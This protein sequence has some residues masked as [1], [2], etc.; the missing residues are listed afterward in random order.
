MTAANQ[1]NQTAILKRLH[2]TKIEGSLF[3]RSKL[4]MQCGKDTEFRGEGRYVTIQTNTITGVSSDFATAVANEGPQE[5]I[6]FFVTHR[7]EY[8]TFSIDNMLLQ[9]AKEPGPAAMISALKQATD[10]DKGAIYAFNRRVAAGLWGNGGGAIGRLATGTTLSGTTFTFRDPTNHRRVEVG[11][12]LQFSL[13]DGTG[14]SASSA[15]LL[16]S[17]E[18]LTVTGVNRGTGEIT[19][20]QALNNI[21]SITDAAYVFLQGDYANKITGLPGWNPIAAPSASES[22]F[23]IDRSVGD[24]QR[25]AG[26]QRLSLGSDTTYT[27]VLTN[28]MGLADEVAVSFDSLF[29]NPRNWA[30]ASI[31][32]GTGKEVRV[33]DKTYNVSFA[34]LKITGPF[35]EVTVYAEPDCPKDYGWG[36][37]VSNLYLR[38]AGEFPMEITDNRGNIMTL[39]EAVD[40]RRGRI[41][42]Y[43]NFFHENPGQGMVMLLPTAGA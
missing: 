9:T 21:T 16:D 19:V 13:L 24:V 7:K 23:G 17:G 28:A 12:K 11:W 6:R 41:G 37:N 33:E 25:K 20:H 32:F 29:I 8:A 2:G 39:K 1:S 34:T 14:A 38:S 4:A 36:E 3:K 27:P 10:P 42:G 30:K 15:D 35:G 40:E 26:L 22:F 18:T 43:G 5:T 31:E